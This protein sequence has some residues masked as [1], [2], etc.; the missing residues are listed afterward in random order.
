VLLVYHGHAAGREA[1]LTGGRRV[2]V[3][4]TAGLL[5]VIMIALK[6]FIQHQHHIY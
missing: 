6:T 5:G 1:G 2:L 3:T 4:S